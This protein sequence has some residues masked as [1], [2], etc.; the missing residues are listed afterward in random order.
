MKKIKMKNG[1]EVETMVQKLR[2]MEKHVC[3]LLLRHCSLLF[4]VVLLSIVDWFCIWSSTR[5]LWVMYTYVVYVVD[6]A[7]QFYK[8]VSVYEH[9]VCKIGKPSVVARSS[10]WLVKLWVYLSLT[11][12]HYCV[13]LMILLET[14]WPMVYGLRHQSESV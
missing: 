5:C 8:V 10:K 14:Q 11:F 7:I 6:D 9:F 4:N 12:S 13:N 1:E 3:S 2:T